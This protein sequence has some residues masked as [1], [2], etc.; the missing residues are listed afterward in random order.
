MKMDNP[1]WRPLAGEAK[2]RRKGI[3]VTDT[4]FPITVVY[5]WTQT[6]YMCFGGCSVK[7]TPRG[8]SS[9]GDDC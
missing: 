2:R 8:C 9:S 6:T 1:V 5:L 7:V 4:D 3:L